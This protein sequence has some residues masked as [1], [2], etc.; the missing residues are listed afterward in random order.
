MY[1]FVGWSSVSKA[2]QAFF[3]AEDWW[4]QRASK[5][6][7]TAE[8]REKDLLAYSE[9]VNYRNELQSRQ[10]FLE[11]T[12]AASEGEAEP[13]PIKL[14]SYDSFNADLLA[15]KLHVPS[16]NDKSLLYELGRRMPWHNK[17]TVA[18]AVHGYL[19]TFLPVHAAGQVTNKSDR[20]KRNR[21]GLV[22]VGFEVRS[23]LQRIANA[24]A[25]SRSPMAPELWLHAECVELQA[26]IVSDFLTACGHHA[27]PEDAD[28]Y[29]AFR[30][31]W[32]GVGVNADTSASIAYIM[33]SHLGFVGDSHTD[34]FGTEA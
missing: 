17:A 26:E 7:V 32:A 24:C 30:H 2:E 23:L 12:A 3:K 20:G 25:V 13:A 29:S 21:T 8:E 18:Q 33:G 4:Q 6:P 19:R 5:Q 31:S 28:K 22:F 11:Q 16:M 9:Y 15:V 34:G 1:I 27:S 14:P 10:Q